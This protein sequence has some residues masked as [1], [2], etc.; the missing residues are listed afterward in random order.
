MDEPSVAKCRWC[1]RLNFKLI[2][3]LRTLADESQYR[4]WSPPSPPSRRARAFA[5]VLGKLRPD[6]EMVPEDGLV[7]LDAGKRFRTE[8]PP[9]CPFCRAL[10][11][12]KAQFSSLASW[13]LEAPGDELR[14]FSYVGLFNNYIEKDQVILMLVPRYKSKSNELTEFRRAFMDASAW[15]RERIIQFVV[16]TKSHLKQGLTYKHMPDR[17]VKSRIDLSLISGRIKECQDHHRGCKQPIEPISLSLIHCKRGIIITTSNPKPYVALSYVWGDV[18]PCKPG[19]DQSLPKLLPTTIADAIEV[20]LGLGYEFLWVDQLCIDQSHNEEKREQINQ[21]DLIYAQAEIT[22][23][24]AA[25]EDTAYGLPGVGRTPRT[26]SIIPTTSDCIT[27]YVSATINVKDDIISSK[28]ASRGWTYQESLLSRRILIFA[29]DR[30]YFECRCMAMQESFEGELVFLETDSQGVRRGES[31]IPAIGPSQA[32]GVI[33]EG[34]NPTQMIHMYCECIAAYSRRTLRRED[35][36]MNAFI[37]IDNKFKAT[38]QGVSS[39]SLKSVWGLPYMVSPLS[40]PAEVQKMVASILYWIGCKKMRRRPQFPSWSWVG[41]EGAIEFQF[42]RSRFKSFLSN[43]NLEYDG[44]VVSPHDIDRVTGGRDSSRPSAIFLDVVIIPMECLEWDPWICFRIYGPIVFLDGIDEDEIG[45][46][47]D[48]RTG[49]LKMCLYVRNRSRLYFLI[50]RRIAK[51]C[52]ERVGWAY[53]SDPSR[54]SL[55]SYI[56]QEISKYED[57]SLSYSGTIDVG[58]GVLQRTMRI[59]IV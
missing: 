32:A 39:E 25:G 18:E 31:V 9:E 49:R 29:A 45:V 20:T 7:L 19:L 50:L 6:I 11:E 40:D 15:N 35:D 13:Y 51:D 42:P 5:W 2:A 14:A 16:C 56:R 53:I 57:E 55:P 17:T 43:V 4:R 24:A 48:F 46:A 47:D 59:R 37:G 10:F 41:W 27:I 26:G 44:L 54:S 38:R 58:G 30:A 8:T 22:L 34:N 33:A 3:S 12:Q 23:I 52:Y 21:M 1:R 28:W 36:A